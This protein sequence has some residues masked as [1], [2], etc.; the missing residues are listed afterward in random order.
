VL[1]GLLIWAAVALIGGLWG[2]ARNLAGT[3]PE[4]VRAAQPKYRPTKSVASIEWRLRRN[5]LTRRSAMEDR[6]DCLLMAGGRHC[7]ELAEWLQSVSQ[8]PSRREGPVQIV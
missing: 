1:F 2:Q 3:A 7:P 6:R 4:A 5:H 8:Q